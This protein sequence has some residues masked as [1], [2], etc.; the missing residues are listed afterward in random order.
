[1]SVSDLAMH[2]QELE[3]SKQIAGEHSIGDPDATLSSHPFESD[4]GAENCHTLQ[5]SKMRRS[6]VLVLGLRPQAIP[7]RFCVLLLFS[8]CSKCPV[9]GNH[10]ARVSKRPAKN[11]KQLKAENRPE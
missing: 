9:H 3:V 6:N 10:R 7:G 4:P 11:A 1:M 8:L 2:F 5:D